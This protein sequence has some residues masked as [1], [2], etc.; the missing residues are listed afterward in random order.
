M[1]SAGP[2][3]INAANA[4]DYADL[5]LAVLSDR[6]TGQLGPLAGLHTAMYWAAAQGYPTIVTTPVD[7]PLLPVDFIRRLSANKAPVIAASNGRLHPTHGIWPTALHNELALAIKDGMRAA[8]DWQ[9]FCRA[10]QCDFTVKGDTD[11]FT[12]INRPEE[13]AELEKI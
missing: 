8:H 13:L 9:A 6:L 4:T 1:Q 5:S 12:N 7:T 3:A 10:R 2:M 11:P